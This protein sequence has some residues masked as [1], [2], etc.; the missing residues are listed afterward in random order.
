MEAWRGHLQK[1][2]SPEEAVH[3]LEAWS[4]EDTYFRLSDELEWL[5]KVGFQPDVIWRKDL[6]AVLLCV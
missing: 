2:Y 6:W 1:R 5:R 3:Y 4:R